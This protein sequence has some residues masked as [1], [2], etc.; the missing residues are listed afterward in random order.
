MVFPIQNKTCA[1]RPS[2]ETGKEKVGSLS[3]SQ[4]TGRSTESFKW[5]RTKSDSTPGVSTPT[6]MN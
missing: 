4:L 6:S 1:Q 3:R 2:G 5:I